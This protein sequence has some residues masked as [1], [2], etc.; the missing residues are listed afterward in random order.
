MSGVHKGNGEN[1]QIHTHDFLTSH[2][3]H[4]HVTHTHTFNFSNK[5]KKSV[6]GMGTVDY[7]R[8]IIRMIYSITYIRILD[9]GLPCTT[10]LQRRRPNMDRHR[11]RQETLDLAGL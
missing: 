10:F 3:S 8:I 9:R 11:Q 1:V 7:H 6:P 5:L 4:A 2:T